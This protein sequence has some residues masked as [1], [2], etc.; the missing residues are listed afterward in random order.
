MGLCSALPTPE[1]HVQDKPFSSES[2][3]ARLSVYGLDQ[4]ELLHSFHSGFVIT[5]ALSGAQLANVIARAGWESNFVA[6]H[7]LKLA[8]G[9]RPF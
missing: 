4:G 5:L 6:L 2:A 9:L 1:V 8:Q 7:Y 3:E